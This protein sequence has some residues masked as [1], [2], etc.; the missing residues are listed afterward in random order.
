[1]RSRRRFGSAFALKRKARRRQQSEAREAAVVPSS[2][3][4]L[5]VVVKSAT[6]RHIGQ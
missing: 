2:Q 3:D 5:S 6:R 1:M 4:Y